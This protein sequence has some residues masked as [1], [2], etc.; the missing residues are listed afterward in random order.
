MQ[1]NKVWKIA[2]R[3][4]ARG[5]NILTSK[6]VLK[7]KKDGKYKEGYYEKCSPA[8]IITALRTIITLAVKE[9]DNI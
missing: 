9:T 4:K 5:K 1:E 2:E 3:E 8:V 6:W 7:I